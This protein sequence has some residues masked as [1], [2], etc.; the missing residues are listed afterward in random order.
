MGELWAIV[1]PEGK[2]VK[3]LF[4]SAEA[5]PYVKVGG[6]GDVAGSLP[7]ALRA[8]GHDVHFMMPAYGLLNRQALGLELLHDS[9]MVDM[10]WR[11]ENCQLWHNPKTG[12][13]FITNSYFFDSRFQVYGCGDEIEQFV[14]FC[15]AALEACRIEGWQPDIIHAN[16]WHTAA[17]IRLAW[18]DPKRPA[19]VYTIHN[20]AHQ[21]NS[22]PNGWPLLGVYDGHTN[23][24]LMQQAIYSADVVTTV[25]PSYAKEIL[26]PANSFGLDNDLR[27]K[28]DH[29]VGVLNGIDTE[30]YNPAT[31]KHLAANYAVDNLQ[32]KARCKKYLQTDMGLAEDPKAPI[33]GM[34]C[35]L[36]F[37]K[38]VELLLETVDRIVRYSNAQVC[39]L[40]SGDPRLED[41]LRRATERNLG[42]VANFIGFDGG[43]ARQV[44]AGCDILL[45]PS[46]FEPCGLSQMIAMRYGTLPVAHSVGGLRDTIVDVRADREKG[47]GY[48]FEGYDRERMM[49]ALFAA[50]ADYNDN[51][52][53]WSKSMEVAMKRD[54][55]WR[56]AAVEYEK[57]Y[58]LALQSI[59]KK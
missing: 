14:L 31:D 42:R 52:E 58:E 47:C 33:I 23:M 35:R 48:L 15:R 54:F 57:V 37:Q 12:D 34:V 9:F 6:L 22:Y 25:S 43:L 36:D 21:G 49:E 56:N 46:R 11:R 16:D 27:A 39:V 18:A 2:D 55:T 45:M 19:L 7:S 24:N 32:G 1:N 50:L 53:A 38:G 17:A 29:L 59:A 10:D 3:V 51:H 41:G 13:R 26:D 30:S 20:L 28:G 8:L 4:L 40:G 5:V 44:Y